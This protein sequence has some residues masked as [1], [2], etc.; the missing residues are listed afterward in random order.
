MTPEA[1][2][3]ADEIK[4]YF[5]SAWIDTNGLAKKLDRLAAMAQPK[6]Q[7]VHLAAAPNG[8][9][10][11]AQVVPLLWTQE[12][13]PTKSVP[14]THIMALTPFGRFLITW[15]GWKDDPSPT[16]DETPWGEFGGIFLDVESAKKA[17]EDQYAKRV[18]DCVAPTPSQGKGEQG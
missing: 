10:G 16:I 15:K 9:P 12:S 4:R 2:A 11:G 18:A 5:D 6:T 17:A 1:Q 8:S 14:Y 7:D 13:K 3:L